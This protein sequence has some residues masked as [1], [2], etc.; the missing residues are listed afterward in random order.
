[1]SIG[2]S[3]V[4]S[5][6]RAEPCGSARAQTTKSI[7]NPLVISAAAIC[8]YWGP[9]CA[10]VYWLRS[11]LRL[12]LLAVTH[13]ALRWILPTRPAILLHLMVQLALLRSRFSFGGS[14]RCGSAV[15]WSAA[16]VA[17][18][19]PQ[20]RSCLTIGAACAG[21]TEQGTDVATITY[22]PG[23]RDGGWEKI[24]PPASAIL[25][26]LVQLALWRRIQT[27]PGRRF[28]HLHCSAILL[29]LRVQLALRVSFG[30]RTR[31]IRSS[32]PGAA[33]LRR[34]QDY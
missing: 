3:H 6:R 30:T 33:V 31:R 12:I 5:S 13:L 15:H 21:G 11:V 29:R 9:R 34:T 20:L 2:A 19:F 28:R 10:G 32:P 27:V 26:H 17:C 18:S 7:S 23:D 8:L 4:D 1:V 14:L 16:I 24:S 22:G 25:L